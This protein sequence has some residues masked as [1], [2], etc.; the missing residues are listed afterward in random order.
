GYDTVLRL[1]VDN[2]FDKRYWRDAG[3]YLGDD[4][5]FMGAPRTASLSASV[6][7]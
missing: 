6:N 4:Y 2:L 7:F 1:T 3:E 5:L